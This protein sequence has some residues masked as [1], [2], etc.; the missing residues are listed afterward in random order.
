MYC[1]WYYI[2]NQRDDEQFLVEVV[3]TAR[4]NAL[5][6]MEKS[7]YLYSTTEIRCTQ[8]AELLHKSIESGNMSIRAIALVPTSDGFGV[9]G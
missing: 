5:H 9:V 2:L 4:K 7:Q 8:A 3:E 1:R 6:L